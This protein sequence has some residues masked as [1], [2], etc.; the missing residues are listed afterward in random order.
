MSSPIFLIDSNVL[1]AA[2]GNIYPFDVFPSW[3]KAMK[4]AIEDGGIGIL[5]VVGKEL[6]MQKDDLWSWLSKEV[7]VKPLDCNSDSIVNSYSEVIT[8]V[9]QSYKA[10]EAGKWINTPDVADPWLIAYAMAEGGILI[11]NEEFVPPASQKLKVPNV[12]EHFKVSWDRPMNMMRLLN[13]RI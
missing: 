7:D 3:W 6:S 1:I 12:A 9:A 11:T 8:Y 10:T 2:K 5:D 4:K 13:F